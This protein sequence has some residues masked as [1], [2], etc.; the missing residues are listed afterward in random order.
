MRRTR[1]TPSM[2]RRRP[3]RGRPGRSPVG[4]RGAMTAK[5][6]SPRAC[7]GGIT[8][9]PAAGVAVCP[10]HCMHDGY[11]QTRPGRRRD[12]VLVAPGHLRRRVA[13][14]AVDDPLVDALRR[15]DAREAV[16]QDVPAPRD[17]ELR[18]AD[19]RVEPAI[20]QVDI[21]RGPVRPGRR[22]LPTGVPCEARAH[23]PRQLGVQID[24]ADRGLPL[25][26]LLLA[27]LHAA[28]VEVEVV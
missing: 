12:Q 1:R 15:Q 7:R 16:A 10:P 18:P 22:V 8:V 17:G 26:A 14:E 27:E 4:R 3:F 2:T 13:H 6:W 9:V 19:G 24:P 21:E 23:D 11:C 28:G 25:Q 20:H 5:W